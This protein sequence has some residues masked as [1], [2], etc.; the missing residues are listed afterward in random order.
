MLSFLKTSFI[1]IEIRYAF[2]FLCDHHDEFVIY[3]IPFSILPYEVRLNNKLVKRELTKFFFQSATVSDA[4]VLQYIPY[5]TVSV[6]VLC[7]CCFFFFGLCPFLVF[8]FFGDSCFYSVRAN[9]ML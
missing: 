6:V 8:C 7:V 4:F 3:P 1:L 5:T 2:Y 9:E